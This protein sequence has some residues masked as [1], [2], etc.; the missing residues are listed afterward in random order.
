MKI[1]AI[2]SDLAYSSDSDAD[3]DMLLGCDDILTASQEVLTTM[4]PPCTGG[5]W[6][7][8]PP[9]KGS[10]EKY[11]PEPQAGRSVGGKWKSPTEGNKVA[12]KLTCKQKQMETGISG[13][14]CCD[15]HLG[16]ISLMNANF[17]DY[18]QKWLRGVQ[19]ERWVDLEEKL[20]TPEGRT[21]E[22]LLNNLKH[23][24]SVNLRSRNIPRH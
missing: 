4:L 21:G 23:L 2:L 3:D 16:M 8:I 11:K 7:I 14:E 24:P 22:T 1:R 15:Y 9:L 19:R 20:S 18:F 12:E 10:S 6:P 17:E 5:K 13:R